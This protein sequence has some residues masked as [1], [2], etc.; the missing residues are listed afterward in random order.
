MLKN[1]QL[2]NAYIYIYIVLTA[3]KAYSTQS[4]NIHKIGAMEKHNA[5]I[6]KIGATNKAY[7]TQN[8]NIHKIGA[9]EEASGTLKKVLTSE[10]LKDTATSGTLKTEKQKIMKKICVLIA[11]TR[12]L[13]LQKI[14]TISKKIIQP[15]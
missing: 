14:F 6:R 3:L 4:R 12:V 2:K 13:I 9:T 11:P 10:T 7:S 8:R 1:N 5:N 15:C